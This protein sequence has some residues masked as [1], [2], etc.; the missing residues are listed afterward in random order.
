M[1]QR[2]GKNSDSDAPNQYRTLAE[3]EDGSKL[4]YDRGRFD[5]YR[6]TL[7]S[8]DGAIRKSPTNNEFFEFLLNLD[9]PEQTWN[10]FLD[11]A[12][13]INATTDFE[14]IRLDL[15]GCDLEGRKMW[16]GLV[17]AMISEERKQHTRLGKRIKM[18]GVYQTLILGMSPQNAASWSYGKEWKE[19]D[20][21]CKKYGF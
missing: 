15:S 12:N 4:I 8:G 2:N 13:Q 5:E 20:E 1:S 9:E 10:V 18:I 21:E 19:I 11:I 3:Y 17:A 6:V 7:Q 16:G 14:D